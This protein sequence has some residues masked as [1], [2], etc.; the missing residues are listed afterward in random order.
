MKTRVA[1]AIR[2]GAGGA[3]H[4]GAGGLGTA[5]AV[6][7]QSARLLAVGESARDGSLN[8]IVIWERWWVRD[9]RCQTTL[10]SSESRF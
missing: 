2:H 7:F 8:T 10:V 6:T 5:T 9:A 3:R 4:S 1:A